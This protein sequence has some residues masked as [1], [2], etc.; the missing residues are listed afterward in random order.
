MEV[1]AFAEPAKD[2]PRILLLKLR[3]EDVYIELA[4]A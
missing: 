4:R 2:A 3:R 1:I